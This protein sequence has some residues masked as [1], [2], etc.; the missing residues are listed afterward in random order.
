MIKIDYFCFPTKTGD[1]SVFTDLEQYNSNW[2]LKEHFE[3]A[4]KNV[5]LAKEKGKLL[6]FDLRNNSFI[7]EEGNFVDISGRIIF[8]R[9]TIQESD[10][11]LEHIEKAKGKSI[12]TLKD[13][14]IIK[15]WFKVIKTN[16]EFEETIFEKVQNNLDFYLEKYGNRFFI[17]TVE[18]VFSGVCYICD[19]KLTDNGSSFKILM[20]STMHSVSMMGIKNPNEKILVSRA[21]DVIKDEFGKREWRAFVVQNELLSLSRA[22]DDV[23]HI[24]EYV[25]DN[26]KKYIKEFESV[27]PSSYVVD[28]FEYQEEK[29]VIFDICEFNPI[30]ASGV[31]QNNDL[32]I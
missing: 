16:R 23:V 15:N 20:D 11:V 29:N 31:F 1:I 17:K 5:L 30:E 21:V 3:F 14:E 18:K 26:V 13:K 28:F 10:I 2:R 22:S 9:T 24:E 25:Y 19:I 8:P 27:L 32:I 6:L 12:T 7:D 4:Q